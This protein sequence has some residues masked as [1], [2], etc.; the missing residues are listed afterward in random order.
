VFTITRKR[1]GLAR[2]SPEAG[3]LGR[4]FVVLR[5]VGRA[6]ETED[7]VFDIGFA[8]CVFR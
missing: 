1:V 7:G 4:L 2:A 3:M 8:V 5:L 6:D